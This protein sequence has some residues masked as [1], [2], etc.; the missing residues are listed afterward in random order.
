MI[1]TSNYAR[2]H[3]NPKAVGISCTVPV[4]Y[5]GAHIKTLGP[6]W[7]MVKASKDGRLSHEDYTTQY[8]ELLERRIIDASL[9]EQM[10]D[11]TMLLCY[12]S[13]GDFCHRR[14]LAEWVKSKTGFIIPEWKNEK[15]TEQG[16]QAAFVDSVLLF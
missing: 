15:E 12:E 5:K 9:F 7:E 3:T 8:I 11:G 10:E 2:Q 6:T 14:I 1:Y 13:P 16:N 4:W